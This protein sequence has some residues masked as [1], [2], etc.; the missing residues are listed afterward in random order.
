MAKRGR[1][2]K[3]LGDTI[4]QITE[5]TGI[6]A[7][8]K[9]FTEVT[10]IDCGCD[11]RKEKLNN[12]ISYRRNVNCLKEDEYLFLKVLFETNSN[13]LTIKQQFKLQEIYLNVFSVKI[14]DSNCGSCWR[15]IL[16]DLK[17]VYNTYELNE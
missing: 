15:D 11:A 7:A 6:K 3:G 9:L 4:E 13:Q 8:V 17:K 16:S 14:E 5:A 2:A 1:K 10:G 12:L